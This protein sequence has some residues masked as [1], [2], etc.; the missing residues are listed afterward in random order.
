[1]R[2]EVVFGK[3]EEQIAKKIE[4]DIEALGISESDFGKFAL[5]NLRSDMVDY[6]HEVMN[7]KDVRSSLKGVKFTAGVSN[8]EV[9]ILL[10][11]KR[12]IE[13]TLQNRENKIERGKE[14]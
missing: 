10:N 3:K 1:M 12:K 13:D 8:Q 14:E 6:P 5:I 7:P 2:I 9:E 11:I 4:K